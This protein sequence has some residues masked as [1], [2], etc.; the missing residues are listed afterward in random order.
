MKTCMDD[1]GNRHISRR[2]TEA[3]TLPVCG[4]PSAKS[5][6]N[7][8]PVSEPYDYDGWQMQDMVWKDTPE[9]PPFAAVVGW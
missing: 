6:Q 7:M 9:Q 2:A 5:L 4:I 1:F 3:S 8:V